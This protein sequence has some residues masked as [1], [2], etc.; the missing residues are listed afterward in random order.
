MARLRIWGFAA[1]LSM[2]CLPLL[3]DNSLTIGQLIATKIAKVGE[4]ISVA[5]FVRFKVGDTAAE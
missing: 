5:R 2:L 3:A 4:N 1:A